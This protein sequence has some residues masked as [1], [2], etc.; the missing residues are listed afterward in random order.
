METKIRLHYMD[1]LKLTAMVCVCA[2]HFPWAG[3]MAFAPQMEPL[4][5]LRRFFFAFNACAVPLFMM[6]NGALLLEG[7]F[8]PK[9]HY[10]NLFRLFFQYLFWRGL[11]IIIIGLWSGYAFSS[12]NLTEYVNVLLFMKDVEGISLSH[13]WF[14][15]M[16]I[17]I[18][19]WLPLIKAAWD[20]PRGPQLFLPFMGL[21]LLFCFAVD[22]LLLF[23]PLIP[24]VKAAN[25]KALR[26]F[27]PMSSSLYCA[28]LFY[29]L[30]G[31]CIR[32]YSRIFEKAGI[33][34]CGLGILVALGLLFLQWRVNSSLMGQTYD[35]VFASYDNLPDVLL[36]ACVF[37]LCMK[38]EPRLARHQGLCRFM[39]KLSGESLS[40]YYFHWIFLASVFE[41]LHIWDSFLFNILRSVLLCLVCAGL[42][43]GMKRLPLLRALLR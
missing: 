36:S 24:L 1:L 31:A 7:A 42:S 29:F 40:V 8:D 10:R 35:N 18:Y 21:L 27:Q 19:L 26:I 17:C 16:L 37:V 20:S 12:W 11:S 34:A 6:V 30:L 38:L 5:A 14:I 41:C 9:K 2:L 28:M 13:L 39:A 32:R 3:D 33:W 43:L 22:D 25:I 4:P 23:Q 15:P